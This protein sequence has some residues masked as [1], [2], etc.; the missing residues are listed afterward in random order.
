MHFFEREPTMVVVNSHGALNFFDANRIPFTDITAK[1]KGI[2]SVTNLVDVMIYDMNGDR[3]F[4]IILLTGQGSPILAVSEGD[5][6]FYNFNLPTLSDL[7]GFTDAI[8]VQLAVAD[9]NN[10]MLPDVFVVRKSIY[11]NAPNLFFVNTGEGFEVL[12][13]GG[14]ASGTALGRG[15][16]VSLADFNF[17]GF[18]D[19]VVFN[20][21]GRFPYNVG[22]TQLFL[23][24]PNSHNW[25]QIEVIGTGDIGDG[26]GVVVGVKAGEVIQV[27]VINSRNKHRRLHFGIGNNTLVSKILIFWPTHHTAQVYYGMLPNQL[28]TIVDFVAPIPSNRNLE[29]L[30]ERG[31]PKTQC[32]PGTER[33]KPSF[34][35]LGIWKAGTT[36][37]SAT[38][39]HHPQITSGAAKEYYYYTKYHE[40]LPIE[41]YWSLFPCGNA[42]YEVTFDGTAG[43]M[44][45]S[46]VPELL[47]EHHPKAKFIIMLRDPIAR[48]YSHFYMTTRSS[49]AEGP[50]R[51]DDL[52]QTHVKRFRECAEKEGNTACAARGSWLFLNAGLYYYAI[53]RWFA[54]F[55]REQFIFVLFND[56]VG[57]NGDNFVKDIQAFLGLD[58]VDLPTREQNVSPKRAPMFDSTRELLLDFYRPHNK[59]LY[60][61]LQ[62]DYK[63]DT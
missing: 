31:A 15:E 7:Y 32:D 28:L 62:K 5:Y 8:N 60:E 61:L 55:P 20:G 40:T 25:I 50:Q 43:Y 54:F 9:F 57:P 24:T 37:L 18:M 35:I 30:T 42:S 63:W 10:D 13:N 4:D 26:L 34:F 16:S 22:P 49:N 11:A 17:D 27:Q 45:D 33:L 46:H 6:S 44:F 47:H 53:Q 23:N 38:L 36:S 48:A 58:V 2:P 56:L 21:G 39:Y 52:M 19:M 51:F 3:M 41:W 59:L 1:F 14:G 12:P 29:M